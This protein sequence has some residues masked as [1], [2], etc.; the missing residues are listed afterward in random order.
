[1]IE[2]EIRDLINRSIDGQCT[3]EESLRLQSILASNAE[4]KRFHRDLQALAAG[5]A[6]MT[7]AEPP[8]TLKPAIVRALE[9]RR[10]S[11]PRRARAAGSWLE[12]FGL[13]PILAFAGGAVVGIAVFALAAG[14]IGNHNTLTED[15]AGSLLLH[16]STD[17]TFSPGKTLTV[18]RG[19]SSV[20][21]E[22][23]LAEG[24][25]LVR[26]RVDAHAG[27][28]GSL[29]SDPASL[30]VEAA[31]PLGPGHPVL[32]IRQNEVVFE[33]IPSGGVAILYSVSPGGSHAVR[34]R[35]T[36]GGETI[37]DEPVSLE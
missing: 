23:G 13:R 14:I 20:V 36:A 26:I 25:A 35:L 16:G 17:V 22:T 7:P 18:A 3:A 29:Q 4:A 28:T 37:F 30:R 11:S 10:S 6:Q 19:S 33:Q 34:V 31:R 5:M 32:T 15:V 9:E 2:S 21:L 24:L 8:P 27:V 12:A 1:M